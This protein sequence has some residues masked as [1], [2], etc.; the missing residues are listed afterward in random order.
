MTTDPE[1]YYHSLLTLYLP[2]HSEESLKEGFETHAD[3]YK[4]VSH[5]VDHNATYFNFNHNSDHIDN[6]LDAYEE[7][8]SPPETS[9]ND[10]GGKHQYTAGWLS[11][12]SY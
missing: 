5:I 8:K 1:K 7:N 6:A 2:W 4:N 9:W 3:H 11:Y 10:R 12:S